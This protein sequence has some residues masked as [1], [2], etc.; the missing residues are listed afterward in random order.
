MGD[1]KHSDRAFDGYAATLAAGITGPFVIWGL[2]VLLRPRY[3]LV[4]L[5]STLF[6]ALVFLGFGKLRVR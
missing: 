1:S 6:I 5:G 4:A 3:G 2:F